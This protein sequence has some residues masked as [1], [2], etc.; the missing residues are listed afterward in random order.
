MNDID[1]QEGSLEL[2]HLILSDLSRSSTP[3]DDTGCD[4]FPL[5]KLWKELQKRATDLDAMLKEGA[6]QWGL[7]NQALGDLKLWLKQAEKRLES[8]MQGCDSLEETEKRRNNI[9]VC[10]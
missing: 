6:S 10:P 9:Q 4:L 5:Y 1:N 8:E 7:Y 2:L 3:M